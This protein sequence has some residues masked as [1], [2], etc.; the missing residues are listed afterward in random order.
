MKERART[1][2]VSRWRFHFIT[3][4]SLALA[5]CAPAWA[6][7]QR[8]REGP[9][10]GVAIGAISHGEM[11]IVA[12]Y[13]ARILDLAASEPR[14]DPTLRR[15]AGFISLQYFVCFWGLIPGSLT[16]CALRTIAT[17]VSD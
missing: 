3:V 15:L 9:S 11:P 14:T 7:H 5:V 16:D 13:R 17:S 12:K 10:A 4:V 2:A 6:H 8:V 1:P